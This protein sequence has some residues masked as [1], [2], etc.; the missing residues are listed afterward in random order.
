M[1]CSKD[2]SLAI[3]SLGLLFL[4]QDLG[5]HFRFGDTT[6]QEHF[7]VKLKRHFLEQRDTF[8]AF[9]LDSSNL[10]TSVKQNL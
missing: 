8:V 2:C 10:H 4:T 1:F 6:F 5:K 7:C 3:F 9:G